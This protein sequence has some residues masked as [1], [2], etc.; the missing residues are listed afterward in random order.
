MPLDPFQIYIFLFLSFLQLFENIFPFLLV[1]VVD[2]PSRIANCNGSIFNILL[3]GISRALL[4]RPQP[5]N[6]SYESHRSFLKLRIQHEHLRVHA[7]THKCNI[8][9]IVLS[10]GQRH[11]ARA[12]LKVP[13]DA[14][15]I[16][17]VVL[18]RVVLFQKLLLVEELG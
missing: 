3:F 6:T 17:L 5:Y 16:L 14:V 18:K 4:A 8:C 13:T 2:R 7:R 15:Q 1:V 10:R 9:V 11:A 12:K